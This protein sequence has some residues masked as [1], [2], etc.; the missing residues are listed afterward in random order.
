MINTV[1]RLGNGIVLVFD[2]KGEQIPEYQGKYEDV[3]V[4]I[5][6]HAP[7]SARFFHGVWVVSHK[8]IPRKDW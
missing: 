6:A 2:E 3:R 5:L 1:I 4:K 7:K 8:S